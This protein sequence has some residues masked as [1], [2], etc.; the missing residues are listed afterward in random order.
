MATGRIISASFLTDFDKKVIELCEKISDTIFNSIT[1]KELR[2]EYNNLFGKVIY[3]RIATPKVLKIQKD[4][5]YINNE[6]VDNF[7]QIRWHPLL[8]SENEIEHAK[9]IVRI[10]TKSKNNKEFFE[11]DKL[12]TIQHDGKF[13]DFWIDDSFNLPERYYFILEEKEFYPF[14]GDIF[15][16]FIPSKE[17][18]NW[19]QAVEVF[20]HLSITVAVNFFSI[21]FHSI[22]EKIVNILSHQEIDKKIEIPSLQFSKLFDDFIICPLCKTK[23]TDETVKESLLSKIS[24]LQLI[25]IKPLIENEIRHNA[26]NVRYGH[27]WCNKVLNGYSVEQTINIFGEILKSHGKNLPALQTDE[28]EIV[29]LKYEIEKPFQSI[30]IAIKQYFDYFSEYVKRVK[31]KEIFFYVKPLQT[32]FEFRVNSTDLSIVEEYLTEYANLVNEKIDGL[33]INFENLTLPQDLKNSSYISIKQ[34]IVHLQQSV[35][36]LSFEKNVIE[37]HN[38]IL[39]TIITD[40]TETIKEKSKQ[41][42]QI[43]NQSLPIAEI[44][45]LVVEIFAELKNTNTALPTEEER[46]LDIYSHLDRFS[47]QNKP[48]YQKRINQW[49]PDNDDLNE[50]SKEYLLSA[51]FLFDVLFKADT[52]DY[53]PFVLQFCRVIEN[54]L[55]KQLFEAFYKQI[56]QTKNEAQI[57]NDYTWDFVKTNKNKD[58]ATIFVQPTE[59]ELMLAKMLEYLK[60]LNDISFSSSV[61][62]SEFKTFINQYFESSVILS[63][64]FINKI[65]FVRENYRNKAAHP[66]RNTIKLNLSEAQKCQSLVRETLVLWLESKKAEFK[67]QMQL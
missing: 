12:L 19:W 44:K 63:S 65:D 25:Y 66:D 13:L 55:L 8:E 6:L 46:I 41:P 39:E 2:K 34:Q 42:I 53:S 51:E 26:S 56:T 22:Y 14:R 16:Y 4:A 21:D 5:L 33:I 61:L 38:K 23:I 29:F 11:S 24:A 3:T 67:P 35:E 28:N 37:K 48:D 17:S 62:F 49:L 36:I 47:I 20:A 50:L 31:G 18:C 45:Q 27:R 9:K 52:N 58:F 54:E 40:L 15:N 1:D 32:G 7:T 10:Q 57:K 43:F 59:P 60:R 64:D 30:S